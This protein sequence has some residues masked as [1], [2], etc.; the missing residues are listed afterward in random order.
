MIAALTVL[1]GYIVAGSPRHN[2]KPWGGFDQWSAEIRG[3]LLWLGLA[4]PVTTRELILASDPERERIGE[5]FE[6]W[7]KAY[8]R[9]EV[10]TS[11]LIASFG[12]GEHPELLAAL[13]LVAADKND[14]AQLDPRRL[15]QWCRSHKGRIVNGL[16]LHP[17]SEPGRKGRWA[18]F[19]PTNEEEVPF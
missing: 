1:R 10:T 7:N 19:S 15:G 18:V 14:R 9:Q 4:D 16:R 11:E 5:I 13:L 6:Q 17:F 3:A 12:R 2:L 8:D